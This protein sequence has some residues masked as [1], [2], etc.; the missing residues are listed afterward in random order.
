MA[1]FTAPHEVCPRTTTSFEPASRQANSMLPS[2]LRVHDVAGDP[3][4]KDV[5]DPLIEDRLDGNSGID[6]PE[7]DGER[8]L[9]GGGGSNL[10]A[11]V[12]TGRRRGDESRVAVG[13]QRE[14]GVR[15]EGCL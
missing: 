4:R 12:A 9:R 14:G 1:P 8:V 15:R 11:V 6:A 13:K 7:H 5:P 2:T 10:I 3:G